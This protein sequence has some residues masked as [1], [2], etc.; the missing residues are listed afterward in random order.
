MARIIAGVGCSHIPS[1]G[2]ASDNGKTQ[3][4]YWKP[5][6][7][8][9]GP[10]RAWMAKTKPDVIIMIYNDH[11]NAFS[12]ELINTFVL[13]VADDYAPADEGYGPRKVPHVYGDAD[14]ATHMSESLILDEFDIAIANEMTVD[15][16][17]TVPLTVMFDQPEEWPCKVIPFCVNVVKYPQPTANRC[18]QLGKALRRAVESYPEDL[19][20]VIFGTGGM[21]HQLQGERAGLINSDFDKMFLDNLTADPLK[22][23]KIGHTEFMREAGS[24]GIE[25]IMWLTMRGALSDDIKEVYR[26]YHVPASNTG[27]GLIIFEDQ[28]K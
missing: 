3:D 22:L 14:F 18:Y 10:A 7:D 13:G 20:V 28:T 4:P 17:L 25:L 26:Y 8:G 15:H 12:V 23:T 24:E 1:V 21:S 2:A 11:A 6:F 16:G 9:Y 5:L 27:A 19:R